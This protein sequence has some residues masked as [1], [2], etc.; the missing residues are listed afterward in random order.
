MVPTSGPR[1]NS[2]PDSSTGSLD[3]SFHP[4]ST[5]NGQGLIFA[6]NHTDR[7]LAHNRS[8]FLAV[9]LA[10]RH[11]GRS[12]SNH[13]AKESV[14]AVCAWCGR[15]ARA[16][17]GGTSPFVWMTPNAA[18][19]RLIAAVSRVSHGMC[20]ACEVGFTAGEDPPGSGRD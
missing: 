6:T 18:Q 5:T 14:L 2:S 1:Q 12:G 19:K 11:G 16:P 20:D 9:A 8:I 4:P 3:A 15:T 17:A 10:A 7:L 13:V